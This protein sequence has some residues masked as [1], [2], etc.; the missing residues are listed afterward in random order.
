MRTEQARSEATYERHLGS[1]QGWV[2]WFALVRCDQLGGVFPTY[3]AAAAAWMSLYGPVPA[4]IR[5]IERTS[6]IA[7][8]TATPAVNGNKPI[9]IVETIAPAD[10]DARL[11]VCSSWILGDGRRRDRQ[12][13]AA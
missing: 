3:E 6:S 12:D 7:P 8:S 11:T 10:A 5:R 9:R 1:L 13:Y 4:L 2:G